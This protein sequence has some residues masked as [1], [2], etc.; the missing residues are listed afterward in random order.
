M[1]DSSS[2]STPVT[3]ADAVR[4]AERVQHAAAALE[5]VLRDSRTFLAGLPLRPRGGPSGCHVNPD[6]AGA[7]RRSA[8]Q[9]AVAGAEFVKLP[10]TRGRM[11]ALSHP[12]EQAIVRASRS[13]AVWSDYLRART[14]L[15]VARTD[16]A[17]AFLDAFGAAAAVR[18]C[19]AVWLAQRDGRATA[20]LGPRW[21]TAPRFV[22]SPCR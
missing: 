6:H 14:T 16:P 5:A 18:V 3:D 17:E 13:A 12:L 20:R 8:E 10:R 9:L 19:L 21:G 7:V 15:R 22:S 11:P 2:A 1:P 4:V